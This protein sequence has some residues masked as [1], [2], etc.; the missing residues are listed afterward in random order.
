MLRSVR[1]K[2]PCRCATHEILNSFQ[3]LLEA[4]LEAANHHLVQMRLKPPFHHE[5][6]FAILLEF[7]KHL[8]ILQ[9][10]QAYP[11]SRRHLSEKQKEDTAQHIPLRSL[12]DVERLIQSWGHIRNARI[13]WARMS[14]DT[15]LMGGRDWPANCHLLAWSRS[16]RSA[17]RLNSPICELQFGPAG[18]LGT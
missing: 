4:F 12:H 14:T 5:A 7:F 11:E 3:R 1:A 18:R 8:L 16:T 9:T 13:A 6:H 2:L 17:W 10:V 15:T